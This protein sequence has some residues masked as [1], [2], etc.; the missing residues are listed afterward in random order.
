MFMNFWSFQDWSTKNPSSVS[1]STQESG[2]MFPSRAR[3]GQSRGR[4]RTRTRADVDMARGDYRSRSRPPKNSNKNAESSS[5]PTLPPIPPEASKFRRNPPSILLP[6]GKKKSTI[7]RLP[8]IQKGQGE[9]AGRPKSKMWR[10]SVEEYWE[11]EE[12][13]QNWK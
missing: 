13:V 10:W 8:P 11:K 3:V 1:T 9:G 2:G 7:P 5:V 12:L 4:V 6:P